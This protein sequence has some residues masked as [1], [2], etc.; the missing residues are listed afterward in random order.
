[1]FPKSRIH[2]VKLMKLARDLLT[3]KLEMVNLDDDVL[4]MSI[5]IQ[6]EG[7]FS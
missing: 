5:H 6:L 1:M 2:T 3:F 7:W 4:E